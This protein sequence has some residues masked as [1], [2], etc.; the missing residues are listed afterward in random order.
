MDL[1][2]CMK[3]KV[4]A[5]PAVKNQFWKQFSNKMLYIYY[6]LKKNERF[7]QYL[8]KSKKIDFSFYFQILRGKVPGFFSLL[9]C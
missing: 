2:K 7:G 3:V 6:S 4:Q 5:L 1:K 8:K 9:E